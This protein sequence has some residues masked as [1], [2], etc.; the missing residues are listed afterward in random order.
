MHFE[1]V[2]LVLSP[3]QWDPPSLEEVSNEM[4]D[5]CFKDLKED[6]DWPPLNLPSKTDSI[7]LAYG[8]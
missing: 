6:E 5:K 3:L 8:L 1:R 4:V 7:A 2:L